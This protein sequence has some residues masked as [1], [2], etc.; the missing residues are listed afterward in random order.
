MM[1]VLS[2]CKDFIR[3]IPTLPYSMTKVEDVDTDAED[4]CVTGDT[5]VLTDSGWLTIQDL[6]DRVGYVMSHDR[7]YHKFS[8]C[9]K[10]QENVPVFKITTDDG[11]VVKAT[12]NHRFMLADGT[13]KRLDELRVGDE[14]LEVDYESQHPLPDKTG[15]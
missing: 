5:L 2:T 11:K 6:C 8:E 12:A 15:I 14:L 3:T 10:T 4:H 13:W 7:Q 1:Q 9:R